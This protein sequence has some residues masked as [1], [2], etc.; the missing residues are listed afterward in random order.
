MVGVINYGLGNL[1][2]V[3]GA[4]HK[5]GYSY[6]V[7]SDRDELS[8]ATHLV[9]PGVGAY[10]DGMKNIRELGLDETIRHLVLEKKIPILGICLGFQL[11]NVLHA[12]AV[13]SDAW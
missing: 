7:T 6:K 11:S 9:L 12:I 5:L 2:S 1:Y 4:L 3:A 13:S 10:G 8:Q